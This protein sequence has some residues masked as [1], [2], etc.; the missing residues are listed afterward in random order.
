LIANMGGV[1]GT[2][3]LAA[4]ISALMVCGPAWAEEP[5]RLA[6]DAAPLVIEGA[7][8]NVRFDVELAATP[9]QRSRGL[10]FR[11]DFPP[12]RAMLFD[13]GETR[14][15]AMWMKNTPLPLDMLFAESS[16][17]I[18]TIAENTKPF[19]ETVIDSGGPVRYVLELNA[20]TVADK[21]IAIGQIL[22]HPVISR[23]P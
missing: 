11:T 12:D 8:T 3:R 21:G 9:E 16:G 17:R 2:I 1:A 19:S 15:V 6:P 7:A 4:A 10:M 13:F 18:I 23:H 14:F 20:G 22:V 5:M